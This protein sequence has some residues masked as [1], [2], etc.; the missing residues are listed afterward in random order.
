MDRVIFKTNVDEVT[1]SRK[2]VLGSLRCEEGKWYKYVH[3]Y[4]DTATVDGVAGDTVSYD[5]ETGVE[6]NKVVLDLSDSDTVPVPAGVLCGTVD[7]TVD[8]SYYCWIQLTGPCTLNQ[9]IAGSPSDGHPLYQSTTDKTLTKAVEA[10]SAGVYKTVCA[11]C[12]D[13]SAKKVILC[14][15]H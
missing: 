5:A 14:Y 6:N 7:G 11:I 15:P 2:D 9:T 10:D 13:A 3:L 8:T 4:N 1:T 12:N